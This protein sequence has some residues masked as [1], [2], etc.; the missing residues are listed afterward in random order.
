M[1]YDRDDL[2]AVPVRVDPEKDV[3]AAVRVAPDKDDTVCLLL[4]VEGA[5]TFELFDVGIF[6]PHES[7]YILFFVLLH[8]RESSHRLRTAKKIVVIAQD[9][10]DRDDES[11]DVIVLL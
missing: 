4:I 11:L 3:F 9:I 8:G 5:D 7:E 1:Y 10:Y 6:D 2:E